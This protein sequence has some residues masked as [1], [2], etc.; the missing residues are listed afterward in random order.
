MGRSLNPGG[1]SGPGGSPGAGGD[2]GLRWPPRHCPPYREE[3]HSVPE[4]LRA[5]AS[6]Q[7]TQALVSEARIRAGGGRAGE[8]RQAPTREG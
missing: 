7:G 6:C 1:C 8:T 2:P 4:G 5:P 3:T